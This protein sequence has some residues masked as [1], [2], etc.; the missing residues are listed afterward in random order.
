MSSVRTLPPV[1]RPADEDDLRFMD[2]ALDEARAAG[3]RGEVP[4]GAVVVVAGE[5][6]GRGHNLRETLRDPTAHAEMIAL[7]AASTQQA[8]WRLTGAAIYCTLEPCLMCMGGILLARVDRLVY[9]PADPKG[10]AAGTLY[11][12]SADPRLNHA[13]EVV[14]GVRAEEGAELLRAFFSGLRVRRRGAER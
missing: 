8:N 13:V 7:R 11:D 14:R 5:V 3:A 2:L 6:V 9:G 4:I 12:V 10:G 1:P